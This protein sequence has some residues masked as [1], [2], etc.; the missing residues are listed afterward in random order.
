MMKHA[1]LYMHQYVLHIIAILFIVSVTALWFEPH[2]YGLS[3][4]CGAFFEV[5]PSLLLLVTPKWEQ[6]LSC[7]LAFALQD[8]QHSS[9]S[10]P[11]PRH[12]QHL[13]TVITSEQLPVYQDIQQR[14]DPSFKLIHEGNSQH[15]DCCQTRITTVLFYH[16][17]PEI[18]FSTN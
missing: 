2:T 11:G 14:V 5:I 16:N 7:F 17:W 18:I 8:I 12:T 6:N 10:C 1:L 3:L 4:F 13:L 9:C 15:P